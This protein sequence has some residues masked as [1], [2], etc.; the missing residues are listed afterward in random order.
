MEIELVPGRKLARE[1][2]AVVMEHLARQGFHLQLPP[3][4]VPSAFP[5]D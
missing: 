1:A 5:V 4:T 3:P 2:A